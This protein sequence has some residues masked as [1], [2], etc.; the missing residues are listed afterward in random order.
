MRMWP[1]NLNS[2]RITGIVLIMLAAT[3]GAGSVWIW[4]HSHVAWQNHL[5]RAF[6][7]G[8]RL[9]D[10]LRQQASPPSDLVITQLKPN[11]ILIANKGKFGL[12]TDQSATP[13]VTVFSLK[14]SGPKLR[15]QETLS[16][17]IVSSDLQYPVREIAKTKDG[18]AAVALGDVTRLLASYCSDPILFA[19]YQDGYWYKIDGSN[20]WGCDA[21]PTDRRPHAVL[22]VLLGLGFL[23][24]R[25]QDVAANFSA[26]AA[27]LGAQRRSDINETSPVEGPLELLEIATQ[28]EAY[29]E[30]ER[31]ALEKR[32]MVLSAVSHDLGTPATRARLRIA[33]IEDEELREKLERDIDQ[34]T[35]MI[36]SILN[37]TRSELS[38]ERPRRLSLRALI[39]AIVDDYQDLGHPVTLA[40][41]P[42]VKIKM[43]HSV[44]DRNPRSRAFNMD[45]LHQVIV[46]AR[47]LAL[48]RAAT[49][50]IENALKYGRRA[51]VTLE[52][53]ATQAHLTIAD[54]GGRIDPELIAKLT[55]PFSRGENSKAN[56]GFGLGLTIVDT[57]AAQHEG[58]VTF[59]QGVQGLEV[60]FTIQR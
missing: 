22:L 51:H 53:N 23:V 33:L 10:M 29:R 4:M 2:L 38:A 43:Q 16:L 49:N 11:D 35:H 37:Y 17:A 12:L 31:D 46:T 15:T 18:S 32:A 54:Q 25:L 52:A 24:L 56:P 45:G 59:E 40:G 27:R 48:R 26:Y 5:Q 42:P 36:D 28:V 9:S 14:A 1:R 58:A 60:R 50:L 47:P 8:L 39:S 7:S 21:A 34:M 3:I 20:V 13:Y 44:F 55:T 19:R 41:E 6:N 57:I 30:R